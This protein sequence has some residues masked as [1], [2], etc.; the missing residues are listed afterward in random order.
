[1]GLPLPNCAI[2]DGIGLRQELK[3]CL[4]NCWKAF[5][6]LLSSTG[7]GYF[8]L[9]EADSGFFPP[10]EL[11]FLS[12]L[13]FFPQEANRPIGLSDLLGSLLVLKYMIHHWKQHWS[14]RKSH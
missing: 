1:M 4:R 12:L 8:L 10:E 9:W 13:F 5:S 3:S 7:S 2:L 6:T 11:N 14:H